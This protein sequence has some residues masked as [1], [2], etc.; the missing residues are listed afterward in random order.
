MYRRLGQRA[1]T[2][3]T[4][5]GSGVPSTDSWSG[6]RALSQRALECIRFRENGWGVDPEFQ[7]QAR[8]HALK[9]TEVPVVA[10]Y[11]EKAKRNPFSHGLQAV[12]AVLR[13][14]GQHRPLLFF[15]VTGVLVLTAGLAAG[16]WVVNVYNA[17]QVLATGIALLSVLL[18]ILGTL[19]L[20]TGI[21]LHSVRGLILEFTRSSRYDE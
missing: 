11:E 18:S 15:S 17:S 14:V 6:Y 13:L 10:V 3:L 9:V 12:N 21:I 2:A 7:F 20:F 19:T 8:E 4:Q 5:A 16:L 1:V